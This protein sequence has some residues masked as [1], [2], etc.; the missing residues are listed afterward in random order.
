MGP[1]YPPAERFYKNQKHW[2]TLV[3]ERTVTPRVAADTESSVDRAVDRVDEKP[4][5]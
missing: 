5:K 1:L 4:P 2:E 3:A